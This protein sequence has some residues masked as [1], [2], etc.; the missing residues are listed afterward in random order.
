MLTALFQLPNPKKKRFNLSKAVHENF[1]PATFLAS[2]NVSMITS[3]FG[4]NA[5]N[6]ERNFLTGISI[7]IIESFYRKLARIFKFLTWVWFYY[8]VYVSQRDNIINQIEREAKELSFNALAELIEK[9]F[10]N[11]R[12]SHFVVGPQQG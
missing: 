3:I 12:D 4:I 11:Q 2:Q 10:K 7:Y 6:N 9:I 5:L 8:T 1:P